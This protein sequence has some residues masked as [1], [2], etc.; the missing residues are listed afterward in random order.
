MI[1]VFIVVLRS[2]MPLLIA[3]NLR[4]NGPM[5]EAMNT[6]QKSGVLSLCAERSTDK[7][8]R[9]KLRRER[10]TPAPKKNAH[11]LCRWADGNHS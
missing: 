6:E 9:R 7:P 8:T 5:R 3:A 1:A 4:F 11:R 2:F 10:A